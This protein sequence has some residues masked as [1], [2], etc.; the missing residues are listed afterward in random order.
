M[1]GAILGDII[2]SPYEF[3]RGDKVKDFTFFEKGAGFTDDSVMT[4]AVAEAIMEVGADTDEENMKAAFAKSMQK[5]GRIYPFAG[6]GGMFARWL[7]S[8]DPKPYGSF[9]NGSAMRVSSVGWFYDS[10]ERTEEVAGWSAAVS[11]NHEEGIKGAKATAGVIYLARNGADKEEIRKYVTE[12]YHYDLDRT[13]DQIRPDYHMDA[14]CQGTVPE[15]VIALLEGVDYEDVIRGAI[16]LGGDTD[17]LGAIAGA[18]GEAMFEVPDSLATEID[19]RLPDDM[20]SVV[21]EF[22]ETIGS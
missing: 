17:T 4:V 16:S 12:N 9:G 1:I 22:H 2:G 5:W 6:Y 13:L 11:H 3:D 19:K 14:T 15:A 21:K 8:P 20:R 7:L 10:L 18:M